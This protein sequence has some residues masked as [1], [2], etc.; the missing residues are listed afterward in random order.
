M[1]DENMTQEKEPLEVISNKKK[2]FNGT[3]ADEYANS[4]AANETFKLG[5]GKDEITFDAK[6]GFGK[7]TVIL[8]EKENLT[9]NIMNG[10]AKYDAVSYAVKGKDVVV[11]ADKVEYVAEANVNGIVDGVRIKDRTYTFRLEQYTLNENAPATDEQKALVGNYMFKG[12]EYGSTK[13]FEDGKRAL[14]LDNSDFASTEPI[15]FDGAEV[16]NIKVYKIVNGVKTDIT[17][18]Y[19]TA[20]KD[21]SNYDYNKG[22]AGKEFEGGSIVLKNY[23]AKDQK[24]S[25]LTVNGTNLA[26]YDK[27]AATHKENSFTGTRFDES[28]TSGKEDEIFKLGTGKDEI[29]FGETFG[30]DTVYL[31]EGEE[32]TLTNLKN[33]SYSKNGNSI[34]IT[35]K[36]S[37]ASDATETGSVTLKDYLKANA[38]VTVGTDGDLTKLLN[39]SKS[40]FLTYKVAEGK[41]NRAVKFTGTLLNETFV[42]SNKN[43]IINGGAGK[44]DITG[45]KGNDKLY[46]GTGE[47]EFKFAKFSGNDTVYSTGTDKLTFADGKQ[48][49]SVKGNDV[50]I[51][52]KYT[53]AEN[54]FLEDGKVYERS[55]DNKYDA[56]SVIDDNNVRVGNLV[57]HIEG[58][59]G[60][61]TLESGDNEK[62]FTKIGKKWYQNTALVGKSEAYKAPQ[63]LKKGE[64]VHN[65]Y[66]YNT[67]NGVKE[68]ID[69]VTVKNYLKGGQHVSV[70][71]Q[72]L[73]AAVN[74]QGISYGKT[75]DYGKAQKLTGSFLNETFTG[76][77]KADKIYTGAGTDT[78]TA[79]AGNDTIYVN[80]DGTKTMTIGMNDGNDTIVMS[81]KADLKINF[82]L[83][84]PATVEVPATKEG[85]QSTTQKVAFKLDTSYVRKGNDLIINN[86]YTGGD[87]TKDKT[88][89]TTVKNYF[90]YE[91]NS[92]SVYENGE[93]KKKT[94]ADMTNFVTGSSKSDTHDFND[95]SDYETVVIT[96]KKGNDIYNVNSFATDMYID[97]KA[98][99][100]TLNLGMET[101]KMA[102]LFN[103]DKNGKTSGSLIFGSTAENALEGNAVE[104]ANYFKSGKIETITAG[105]DS[106]D[107]NM[108][109]WIDKITSNVQA[110]LSEPGRNYQDAMAVLDGGKSEDITSLLAVYQNANYASATAQATQPNPHAG[111]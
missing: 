1:T 57:Y 88:Q 66:V 56:G 105:T 77:K 78:I 48:T 58:L 96:D 6:E 21:A 44:D 104:I 85:G 71:E 73:A 75:A 25:G 108:T 97:D 36:S 17:E 40:D 92:L 33:V 86:T 101:D 106:K 111:V 34:T 81:S 70:G 69:T 35:S 38:K 24:E 2:V 43:D 99:R 76:G 18:E 28:V 53:L 107:V 27:Y 7:D 67:K 42:G 5:A 13:T 12:C 16:S 102:L 29:E 80:G 23:A 30:K 91:N 4:T 109:A 8:T 110:W 83:P 22:L 103:V 47:N 95:F 61:D 79:G 93:Y 11:T 26:T 89:T 87:L 15:K 100:D 72:D 31:S 20:V 14:Y 41:E 39:D 90:K 82:K 60:K 68:T 64:F 19:K 10:K 9:L 55:T 98:G 63:R 50:V 94:N 62:D 37:G 65:G 74:A 3:S 32:L 52:S 49:Y 54:Q 46:G 45:G 84:D 51:T 59:P